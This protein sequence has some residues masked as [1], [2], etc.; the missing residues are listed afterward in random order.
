M[1][2]SEK[3]EELLPRLRRFARACTGNVELAD[4]CV[5]AAVMILVQKV[6]SSELDPKQKF[7]IYLYRL[8]EAALEE[9]AGN[10]FE[11]QAW[12]AM[13][14]VIVE[15]FSTAEAA[16][17]LRLDTQYVVKLVASGQDRARKLINEV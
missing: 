14:L 11:R 15:G 12:R 9:R 6:E 13:I 2:P 16:Q 10:S 3:L 8:V 5:E 17:I 4:E 7:D 1:A